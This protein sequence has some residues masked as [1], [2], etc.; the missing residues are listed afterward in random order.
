[1]ERRFSRQGFE[2]E[3]AAMTITHPILVSLRP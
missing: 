2:T 1:M 3:G